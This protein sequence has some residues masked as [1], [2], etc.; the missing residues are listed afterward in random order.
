MIEGSFYSSKG[1]RQFYLDGFYFKNFI[2]YYYY[3]VI[4]VTNNDSLNLNKI[5]LNIIEELKLFFSQV[6]LD[7]LSL[8]SWESMMNLFLSIL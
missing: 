2:I 4:F 1:S 3:K 8:S 6:C 7:S 5:H